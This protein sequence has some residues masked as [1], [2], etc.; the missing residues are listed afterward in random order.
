MLLRT[1]TIVFLAL[2]LASVEAAVG[3]GSIRMSVD[4]PTTY[5]NSNF[6]NSDAIS[7]GAHFAGPLFSLKF[8]GANRVHIDA[9]AVRSNLVI[10]STDVD[11]RIG[12][13][14]YAKE[15]LLA[16]NY[17][18][19]AVS[20]YLKGQSVGIP[21]AANI[22]AVCFI[23]DSTNLLLA[24]D[25]TVTLPAAGVIKRN[26][27]VTLQNGTFSKWADGAANLG[28]RSN[29]KLDGLF[30]SGNNL[31]YSLDVSFKRGAMEGTDKDIWVF[32]TNTLATSLITGL[33][34]AQ[35]VDLGD[36]DELLDS[37]G[38]G[39]SD[40]EEIT[41]V[42]EAGTTVGGTTF[43]LSPAPFKSN[44]FAADSDNDGVKDG[45]EA[46][47]GTNPINSTDYLRITAITGGAGQIVRWSS[48]NGKV[49]D[50]QSATNVTAFSDVVASDV[51]AAGA[52]TAI[53]NPASTE[54][55][56]YRVRVK[57]Q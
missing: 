10:F 6:Q 46:V 45:D 27:I 12:L 21:S 8:P 24:F 28:L 5:R 25:T 13:T 11:F 9:L 41:G 14:S 19:G 1:A 35:G 39:L 15:D 32:N 48:V 47:A 57:P 36:F 40:L 31:Y 30:L 42:D 52:S 7:S 56:F 38:D 29:A 3:P 4:I 37:D 16:Y 54:V 18:S 55:R 23:P 26:D 20:L 34:L 50:V 49:Y 44:P 43:V 17:S 51:N 2:N 53:T 22:T 33:E